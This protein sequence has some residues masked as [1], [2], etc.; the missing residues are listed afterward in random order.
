MEQLYHIHINNRFDD[1]FVEGNTIH[2]GDEPN[3]FRHAFL[4][5]SCTFIEKTIIDEQGREGNFRR[6]ILEFFTP[7]KIRTLPVDKQLEVLVAA[8]Q[9]IQNSKVD[10][11]EIILEDVRRELYPQYPS[12]YSCFWLTDKDSLPFWEDML[13]TKERSHQIFEVE[14][15]GKI[16]VSTDD[17]LPECHHPHNMQY[18]EA[19]RY[20]D[21]KPSDLE[22][23]TREYLFEGKLTLTK[24]VK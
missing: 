6:D 9:Y 18:E 15:Q 17:L 12:R 7:E 21:P 20:W 13:K 1:Q 8:R 22:K 4:N 16:F 19:I 14:P 24:R 2:T 23:N 5:R 3:T 10:F 11:R